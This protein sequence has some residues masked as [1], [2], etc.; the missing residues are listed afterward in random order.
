M[1]R[2]ADLTNL[3]GRPLTNIERA[4]ILECDAITDRREADHRAWLDRMSDRE[5]R[6]LGIAARVAN[7]DLPSANDNETFGEAA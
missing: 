2:I 3:L 6:Y 4:A 1:N 7:D 5:R